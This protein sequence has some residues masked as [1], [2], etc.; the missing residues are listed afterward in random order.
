MPGKRINPNLIKTHYSYTADELAKRLGVHKNT[1]RNWA[2]VGLFFLPGRPIL[3]HGGTVRAFI[4]TRNAGRRAPC[5]PGTFYCFRC[6]DRRKPALGMIDF[7][8]R[9]R[10][11]GNLMAICETCGATMN[12][13]ARRDALA[14]IMPGLDVQIRQRPPT[15][16]GSPVPS[17]DCTLKER[18]TT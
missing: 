17:L 2:R 7:I 15:L 3:F 14:A 9:L 8:D 18:E 6:R 10:G 16:S 11:A 1:I 12:R 5:P 13:R 4:A